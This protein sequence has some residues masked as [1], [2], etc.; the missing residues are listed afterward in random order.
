M[1]GPHAL[2][3]LIPGDPVKIEFSARAGFD[4]VGWRS[5]LVVAPL[6]FAY[7]IVNTILALPPLVAF[8]HAV[9]QARDLFFG[10][11]TLLPWEAL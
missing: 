6:F 3:H 5:F 4:R 1:T 9:D 8:P 11:E 7:V 10:E 2:S